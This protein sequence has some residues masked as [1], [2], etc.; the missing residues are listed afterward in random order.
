L[1][2]GK[3]QG[4][5]VI[6]SEGKL[7]KKIIVTLVVTFILLAGIAATYYFKDNLAGFPVIKN[8]LQKGDELV[9]G[10]DNVQQQLSLQPEKNLKSGQLNININFPKSI[11]EIGEKVNGEFR[12]N[13]SGAPFSAVILE[14]NSRK[15]FDEKINSVSIQEIN[16]SSASGEEISAFRIYENGFLSRTDYF[17]EEAEYY[18][19]IIV[20]DCNDVQKALK[21]D[22]EVDNFGHDYINLENVAPIKSATKSLVVKGGSIPVGVTVCQK[23]ND[24]TK[25][26]EGCAKGIQKCNLAQQEC[27]DCIFDSDSFSGARSDCKDGYK[28]VSNTCIRK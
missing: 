5:V 2:Y 7:S 11:Y 19:T 20:Y 26:C 24:C 14:T 3:K 28:C 9:A 8:F 13:Y 27:I 25:A 10:S 6:T 16:N 22:C 17:N 21:K 1:L 4:S 23:N 18:Y 15:G 12:I